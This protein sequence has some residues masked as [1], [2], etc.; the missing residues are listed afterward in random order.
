[1]LVPLQR[2]P[3]WAAAAVV[4]APFAGA[5]GACELGHCADGVRELGPVLATPG[6]W[7]GREDGGGEGQLDVSE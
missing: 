4:G 7:A 5:A 6:Q 3:R 1:M 2:R